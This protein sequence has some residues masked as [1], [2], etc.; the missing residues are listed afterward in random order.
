MA[1]TRVPV[2]PAVMDA[3]VSRLYT[4]SG[5]RVQR[6]MP[7]FLELGRT[8]ERVA[9]RLP[10]KTGADHYR[11]GL[12]VVKELLRVL[13]GGEVTEEQV[14]ADLEEAHVPLLVKIGAQ[15]DPKKMRAAT[16]DALETLTKQSNPVGMT[17]KMY[18]LEGYA[19]GDRNVPQRLT[20]KDANRVVREAFVEGSRV[21]DDLR[22]SKEER[23][24][25]VSTFTE[26]EKAAVIEETQR[27]NKNLL[28]R[29]VPAYARARKTVDV[30]MGEIGKM[31]GG[32]TQGEN[33]DDSGHIVLRNPKQASEKAAYEKQ[34]K[35][36]ETT[37][38]TNIKKTMRET[39]LRE[40]VGEQEELVEKIL[41]DP[42]STKEAAYSAERGL[43]NLRRAV[44][45]RKKQATDAAARASGF[46][47]REELL[48]TK[49]I[50]GI[51]ERPVNVTQRGS[52]GMSALE[53]AVTG[54]WNRMPE[55]VRSALENRG[56]N[57]TRAGAQFVSKQKEPP[58]QKDIEALRAAQRAIPLEKR[59]EIR[60]RATS[61]AEWN[62]MARTFG[63]MGNVDPQSLGASEIVERAA[64]PTTGAAE[65]DEFDA[66]IEEMTAKPATRLTNEA[67]PQR[68]DRKEGVKYL[69][70][71]EEPEI[72][73]KL[74]G[75]KITKAKRRM[76]AMRAEGGGTT[77]GTKQIKAIAEALFAVLSKRGQKGR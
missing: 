9:G 2:D 35:T 17:A 10:Q 53:A 66:M 14:L 76:A 4:P 26:P 15:T 67:E 39:N 3:L 5:E 31:L 28:S 23:S 22:V 30:R 20:P 74:A 51:Q 19:S 38:R 69:R 72:A 7:D 52:E 49:P 57:A 75:S 71:V 11:R 40:R 12:T 1:K 21:T 16:F 18:M 68:L 13:S 32:V 50:A 46:G 59:R 61:G 27:L 55:D 60:G 63:A 37:A 62:V 42:K 54:Q 65:M 41:S 24:R 73:G 8:L 64:E 45:T 48:Q 58:V 43:D 44:K 36:V 25:L 77:R 6:N 56:L 33:V 34:K 29:E 47:T 70:E